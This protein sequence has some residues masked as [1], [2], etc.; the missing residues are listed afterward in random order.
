[1]D[2]FN[3]YPSSAVAKVP[4]LGALIGAAFAADHSALQSAIQGGEKSL[5]DHLVAF[6]NAE[7]AKLSA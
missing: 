5:I 3:G 1:M 4:T 2:Y 6:C 7:A